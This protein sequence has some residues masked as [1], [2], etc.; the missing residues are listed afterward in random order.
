MWCIVTLG[1]AS[2]IKA[3]RNVMLV[4]GQLTIAQS[5]GLCGAMCQFESKEACESLCISQ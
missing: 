1:E 5:R 2:C 3:F 4:D